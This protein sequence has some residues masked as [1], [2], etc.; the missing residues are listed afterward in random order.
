MLRAGLAA[1][2]AVV[3]LALV[4]G[5]I[6]LFSKT[7]VI[8]GEDPRRP[9]RFENQEAAE[10]FNKAI[11]EKTAQIG[12]TYVGI[13]FVTLYSKD[14]QLSDSAH[15]NDCVIRCDTDQDGTITLVEAKTF[16]TLK[17]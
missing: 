6:T 11:K 4:P 1:A 14:R 8:R 7:E 2:L 5:C 12:G 16:A 17:D 13:P 9:I 15:F 10:A 3:M